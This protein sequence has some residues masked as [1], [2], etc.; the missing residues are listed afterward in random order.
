MGGSAG[1]FKAVIQDETKRWIPLAKS[2]HI[3]AD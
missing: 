1:D 2:L 3:T